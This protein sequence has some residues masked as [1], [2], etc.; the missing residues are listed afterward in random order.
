VSPEALREGGQDLAGRVETVDT[1][2]LLNNMLDASANKL[3]P[4]PAVITL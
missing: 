1:K 3:T 2:D 4:R